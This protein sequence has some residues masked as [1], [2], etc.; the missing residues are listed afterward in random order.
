MLETSGPIM[1]LLE[2]TSGLK[3]PPK[4][5][6]VKR[7]KSYSNFYEDATS[8]LSNTVDKNQGLDISD[9]SRKNETFAPFGSN[10]EDFEEDLL[11]ASQEEYQ[12]GALCPSCVLN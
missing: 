2:D 8:Y 10:F 11:N 1:E 9:F 7:A 3:D 6:L 12:Y 5:T 4:A